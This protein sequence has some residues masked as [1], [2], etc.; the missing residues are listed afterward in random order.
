MIG[1]VRPEARVRVAEQ[2]VMPLL[3][4]RSWAPKPRFGPASWVRTVR[5]ESLGSVFGRRAFN[6]GQ[7]LGSPTTRTAKSACVLS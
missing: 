4:N 1:S 2:V 6:D 7:G 5:A 3:A